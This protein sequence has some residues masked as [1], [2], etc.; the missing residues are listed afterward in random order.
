MRELKYAKDSCQPR[1][2]SDERS[3]RICSAVE[4]SQQKQTEQA[5]KGKRGHRQSCFEQR[6]PFDESKTHQHE[7]P[8]HGHASRYA[9]ESARV[10]AA[11][12]EL[13]KIQYARSG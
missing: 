13:C 10:N 9:Q 12:L 8:C 3:K 7:A 2:H 4:S 11:S 1:K 5:A 6:S